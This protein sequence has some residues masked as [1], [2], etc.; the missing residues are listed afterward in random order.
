MLKAS[1]SCLFFRVKIMFL[2]NTF[3]K[4]L[5]FGLAFF[6]SGAAN[7]TLTQVSVL[8][9]AKQDCSS[10]DAYFNT[11]SGFSDCAI[12]V[13]DNNNV[14]AYLSDVIIKF[15][16]TE[17]GA[18]QETT[19]GSE[20]IGKINGDSFGD[21][22]SDITF[23]DSTNSSGDWTYN[24]GI[25]TYPDIRFWTAKTGKGGFYLFWQVDS[26]EIPDNC[27][28]GTDSSNLSFACMNLAQSVTQGTW[29]T[30]TAKKLSHITF[31][32]GLCSE[33]DAN[34]AANC[35]TTTQQVPEP[36]SIA[37]FALALFG[38]AVNRKKFTS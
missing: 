10:N 4:A 21:Q 24:D 32:G 19:V 23:D 11:G 31:F 9:D 26:S 34:N 7:A 37:L 36:T 33:D 13:L 2:K 25:Y 35:G 27:V 29:S 6:L 8:I 18:V 38:I 12:S 15:D 14:R 3:S 28:T 5:L 17:S 16:Y 22:S 1:L 30:P 20:Y